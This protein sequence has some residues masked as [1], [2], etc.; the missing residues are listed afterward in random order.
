MLVAAM[1]PCRCGYYPDM[2]KCRCTQNAIDRYLG[3]ISQPLID[4]MDMCVEA[5]RLEFG[6]LTGTEEAESS[7]TIRERVIC[8]QRI[9]RER[10]RNTGFQFNSQIPATQIRTFCVLNRSQEQYMEQLYKSMNLTARSYHKIL[11]VART[12]ADMEA[13]E[14]IQDRHLNEAVCYRSLDKKFWEKA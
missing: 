2:Q 3:R 14:Q 9:Q 6:E 1:N 10:Y 5:P 12:L 8:A 13:E 11:K 7:E 4:R